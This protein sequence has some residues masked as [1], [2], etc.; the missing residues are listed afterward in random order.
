MTGSTPDSSEGAADSQAQPKTTASGE[1]RG[2]LKGLT[3]DAG[4]FHSV[5]ELLE[6]V[7]ALQRD[8]AA[9]K[10]AGVAVGVAGVLA[11]VAAAL[12]TAAPAFLEFRLKAWQDCHQRSAAWLQSSPPGM[13]EGNHLKLSWLGECQLVRSGKL[14]EEVFN[15]TERGFV[16]K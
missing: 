11:L 14:G 3:D 6:S 2:I 16:A 7:P 9:L 4:K 10:T 13:Q 15:L 5:A 1:G 12:I 8:I